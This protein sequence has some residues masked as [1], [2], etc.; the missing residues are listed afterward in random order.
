M[1]SIGTPEY[2][3]TRNSAESEGCACRLGTT[4]VLVLVGVVVIGP[5]IDGAATLAGGD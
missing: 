1:G 4:V 3:W 2:R 5:A